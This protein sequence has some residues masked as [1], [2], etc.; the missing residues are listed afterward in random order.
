MKIKPGRRFEDEDLKARVE[1]PEGWEIP[2]RQA[3]FRVYKSYVIA[4]EP[5]FGKGQPYIMAWWWRDV[6]TGKGE[7]DGEWEM[8]GSRVYDP[9]D[10]RYLFEEIARVDPADEKSIL[11]FCNNY[12]LLGEMS[13]ELP[14]RFTGLLW[15]DERAYYRE[16]L[17]FFTQ[18]VRRMQ[19]T[20]QLYHD[21]RND[22]PRLQARAANL[23]A[24]L[25]EEHPELEPRLAAADHLTV[26]RTQLLRWINMHLGAVY[27]ALRLGLDG[28][29]YP[30]HT[31]LTLLGIAYFQLYEVVAAEVELRECDYCHSLFVPRNHRAHFCPP[32]EHYRRSPCENKYNQMVY[33]TR[34]R[35]RAGKETVEAAAARL[36]R[37]VAEVRSWL[38]EVEERS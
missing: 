14:A 33:H 21:I 35:I 27:P 2:R 20:L 7:P 9:F 13:D 12:G 17:Q 31:G 23:K 30:G 6:V 26:A 16:S 29:L 3:V 19:D 1:Y 25:L 18:A 28:R 38:N 22:H 11:A 36:G 37:P 24:F 32:P 10:V 4:P 5:R 8:Q 34:R 15:N